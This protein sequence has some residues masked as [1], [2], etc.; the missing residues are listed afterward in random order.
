MSPRLS[1]SDPTSG[2]VIIVEEIAV[3]DDEADD[4]D[5]AVELSIDAEAVLVFFSREDE[6]KREKNP[7]FFFADEGSDC[8]PFERA[9]VLETEASSTCK[10]GT[11]GVIISGVI[12][13]VAFF[14]IGNAD[15]D[16]VDS[17]VVL[18]LLLKR[19][20][21]GIASSKVMSAASAF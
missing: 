2:G 21:R 16:V 3:A 1:L 10:V 12:L 18:L 8:C 17:E 20:F 14:A 19:N 15:V 11:V 6:E 9:E 13:S 5:A 7:V 4:V